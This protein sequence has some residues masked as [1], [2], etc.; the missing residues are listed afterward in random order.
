MTN[1]VILDRIEMDKNIKPPG[2]QRREQV[3]APKIVF[4]QGLITLQLLFGC[5]SHLSFHP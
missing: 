3:I 1:I 5:F 2:S 4:L